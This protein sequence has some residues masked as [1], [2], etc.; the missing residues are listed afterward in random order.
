MIEEFIK[1][2]TNKK[3][4]WVR[5]EDKYFLK[6][7][8]LYKVQKEIPLKPSRTGLFLGIEKEGRFNPSLALLELI[9]KHSEKK[10]FLGKK[11][12][13]FFL[14]GRDI[15][16]KNNKNYQ[17]RDMVLIQNKNDENIGLGR[18]DKDTMINVFDRGDFLRRERK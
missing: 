15:F 17:D 12:E 11:N 6:D 18:F 4:E 14:C 8:F 3:L 1:K 13:W 7:E 16:I 5:K 2:F 10:L 9:S